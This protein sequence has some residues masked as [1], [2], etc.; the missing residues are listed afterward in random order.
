MGA[1]GQSN[2]PLAKIPITDGNIGALV[3]SGQ[4]LYRACLK[5]LKATP[6]KGKEP[7]FGVL[8]A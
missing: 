2:T 3:A 1:V 8:N 7:K 6:H 5:T 4:K